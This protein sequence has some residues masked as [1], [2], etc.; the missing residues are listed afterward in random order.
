[1]KK[2]TLCRKIAEIPSIDPITA[3]AAVAAVGDARQFHYG[4][5]LSA[6][7]ELVPRQYSSGGKPRQHGVSRRGDTY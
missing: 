4:R 7:L 3:A 2:S 6:W 1:M 5:H